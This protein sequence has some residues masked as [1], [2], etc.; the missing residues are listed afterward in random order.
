VSGDRTASSDEVESL[1]SRLRPAATAERGPISCAP[2]VPLQR[3]IRVTEAVQGG[4]RRD[5]VPSKNKAIEG[6]GMFRLGFSVAWYGLRIPPWA[7]RKAPEK[8]GAFRIFGLLLARMCR[9]CA[10]RVLVQRRR[11]RR[12]QLAPPR[13]AELPS[14]LPLLPQPLSEFANRH[15]GVD[16]VGRAFSDLVRSALD[17][18]TCHPGSGHRL[19]PFLGCRAPRGEFQSQSG[20]ANR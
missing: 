18:V 20:G 14:S 16:L 19:C 17:L 3:G 15:A 9:Q 4:T 6:N 7:N 5:V 8:S 11:R 2:S 13:A 12:V 1:R 10:V